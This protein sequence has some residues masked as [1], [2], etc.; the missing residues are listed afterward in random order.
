MISM[1]KDYQKTFL[2][3]VLRGMES[4]GLKKLFKW[5]IELNLLLKGKV[6]YR[7]KFN[8]LKINFM[9]MDDLLFASQLDLFQYS[10]LRCYIQIHL[11]SRCLFSA[12]H[13]MYKIR[14]DSHRDK[15]SEV[16]LS[17]LGKKTR[18][19]MQVGRLYIEIGE[20]V[21][22]KGNNVNGDRR[23]RMY[24]NVYLAALFCAEWVEV[25]CAHRV[26]DRLRQPSGGKALS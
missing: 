24:F 3:E 11:W 12:R 13:Q 5:A 9:K 8:V 15:F 19:S 4:Q 23:Y 16:L 18:G 25:P 21:S 6:I 26:K 7:N 20:K 1:W 10:E 17:T 22:D 14:H 2:L